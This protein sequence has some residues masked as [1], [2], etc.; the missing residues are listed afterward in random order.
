MYLHACQARGLGKFC[1]QRLTAVKLVIFHKNED[2]L[3]KN[4]RIIMTMMHV[5]HFVSCFFII[6]SSAGFA[7][8]ITWLV[9]TQNKILSRIAILSYTPSVQVVRQH[10]LRLFSE[11][12]HKTCHNFLSCLQILMRIVSN[13]DTICM[14]MH[15]KREVWQNSVARD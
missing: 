2:A 13:G 14:F 4:E 7:D 6:R 12:F 8:M 1:S 9:E 10:G 3:V 11:N 5:D 15:A